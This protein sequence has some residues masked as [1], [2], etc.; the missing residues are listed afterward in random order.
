VQFTEEACVP[1]TA[2]PKPFLKVALRGIVAQA[3][4]DGV[5]LVDADYIEEVNKRRGGHQGK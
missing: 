4:A 3:R 5:S 1:L 2:I